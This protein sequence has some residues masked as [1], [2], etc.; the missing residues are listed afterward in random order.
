MIDDKLA[1]WTGPLVR[2]LVATIG[3]VLSLV[4]TAAAQTAGGSSFDWGGALHGQLSLG[5]MADVAGNGIG[6]DL[7]LRMRSPSGRGLRIEGAWTKHSTTKT[8][9]EGE[10]FG[11]PLSG[12]VSTSHSIARL[13]VGPQWSMPAGEGRHEF[14]AMLGIAWIAPNFSGAEVGLNDH[15]P[16]SHAILASIGTDILLPVH[17]RGGDWMEVGVEIQAGAKGTFYGDP[18]IVPDGSGNYLYQS[19]RASI[20][21]ITVRVGTVKTYP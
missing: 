6:L 20:S 2:G 19:K 12:N 17:I 10:F 3:L 1:P 13:A 11:S 21:G 15:P 14:Y 8:P 5:S 9:T 18:P 16:S 4:P 7:S